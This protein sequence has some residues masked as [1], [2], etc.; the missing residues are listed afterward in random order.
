MAIISI[1]LS[2]RTA[3]VALRERLAF[4]PEE[5]PGALTALR[6]RFGGGVI[7]STCNRMEA[8]V[9]AAGGESQD[10]LAG[11]ILRLKGFPADEA[12]P[13]FG[14]LTGMHAVRHLYRVAAGIDSMVIG[15]SQIAG[16]VRD[17]MLAAEE[18]GALDPTLRRLFHSA[19]GVGRRARHETA[20]GRETVSVSSTAVQL[21]RRLL[22]DLSTLTVLL[23]S[24]GEAGKL[25]ARHIQEF[26][27]NRLLVTN[28]SPERAQELVANLGGRAIPFAELG[29]ALSEADVV[30]SSS[31]AEHYLIDRAVVE[32]ALHRRGE[33]PLLFIDIAVPRDV[34][35]A[36]AELPGVHL[37]D[38]DA[39]QAIAE[40][41]LKTRS[42]EVDKVE[43][44]V[45]EE[46][47]RFAEW[48]RAR[49]VIPTIAALRTRAE[50]IREAELARTLARLPGLGEEDRRRIEAMSAAMMKRLL[51]D[52][53]ATLRRRKGSRYVEALQ[54]L[55][56][57]PGNA[58]RE[59]DADPGGPPE[60]Q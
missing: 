4:T 53:I 49:E 10:D 59:A 54:E 30:L 37:Y 16:Q 9:S 24:A 48:W 31:A 56:N 46:T 20:I 36:V 22:G 12:Q 2:H 8:Y 43:R 38:I 50:E 7:L 55:F 21:V 44:I 60:P 52:P 33:R 1:G 39:I 32:A 41:N 19:V 28:R 25:A 51:H 11:A 17:A 5:M 15:E 23:V 58:A 3:P 47:T 13:G 40:E 29:D 45:E 57:L 26:G 6:E 14:R 42:G 27:A 35:P 18:Q 34:D